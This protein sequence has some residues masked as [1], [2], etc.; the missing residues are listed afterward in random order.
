MATKQEAFAEANRGILTYSGPIIKERGF[1]P[2]PVAGKIPIFADSVSNPKCI[3]TRLH[4]EWWEEQFFYMQNGYTTGG[5]FIP[6][7]YY[8][9]LN[10]QIITGLLGRQYPDFTDTHYR[11]YRIVH[12]IKKYNITGIIIPKARRK[13]VSWFGTSLA[14]NGIRFTDDYR[15]GVA[16]G[17]EG[18]VKGFRNKLY[19][20]YNDCPPEM[21]LGHL[22][23]NKDEFKT[24]WEEEGAIGLLEM[25]TSTNLFR[26]MKDDATKLEGEYFHD[27]IAEEAGQFPKV[28][29]FITSIRPTMDLGAQTLGT[30]YIYG[31]GGDTMKASKGFKDL[32]H[33]A[34]SLGLVQWPILG[35]EYYFP[36]YVG[37]RNKDDTV[38]PESDTLETVLMA[39]GYSKE[40]ILGCEDHVLAEKDIRNVRALLAKNPNKKLLVQWNQKYPLSV[41]EIFTSSGSNNFNNDL[42][43]GQAFKIDSSI[44][45]IRKVILEWV[46][47]DRGNLVIPL[48]VTYRDA[49]TKDRD[50]MIVEMLRPPMTNIK[51]LDIGGIDGYN[52][53][54]ST[55]SKSLGAMNVVRRYDEFL[56]PEEQKE[57]EPLTGRAIICQY[58]QRPPRKEAFFEICLQISVLYNLQKN[59]MASAEADLVIQYYKNQGSAKYL[60]PRPK[61]FDSP[62]GELNNDYGAKM[63]TYSKPRMVGL[64]QS[65]VEDNTSSL[66]FSRT[67]NDLICY[68]DQNIGTDYDSVDA[69]G[70][71]LMRI[72]DMK[73]KPKPKEN[74]EEE[75]AYEL[76]SYQLTDD[77]IMGTTDEYQKLIKELFLS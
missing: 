55:T 29:E 19:A 63:T 58:Y 44:P 7:V 69:L 21:Q 50:W 34:D 76:P 35:N 15:M 11:L 14:N 77:G 57:E 43:Y 75:S 66:M 47:D 13:G 67:I 51:D 61:S 40:Q 52:E 39:E 73:K 38:P 25:I 33:S 22:L 53:D 12:E 49:T 64:L 41:E 23:K 6:G 17:L 36:Y 45:K 54:V 28:E 59:T 68:D 56:V 65:W 30:I 71:C 16:G 62:N 70:L 2:K 32:W 72:E 31:T 26:T 24:G 46:K 42:L 9:Y 48:K 8:Q 37:A 27:V 74:L 3:G 4:K 20:S 10:F 5:I 60:S 18:Y 1:N